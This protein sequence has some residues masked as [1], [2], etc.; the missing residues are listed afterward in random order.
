MRR[1]YACMY[2]NGSFGFTNG[3]VKMDGG[4]KTMITLSFHLNACSP[5][6]KK[7]SAQTK[8]VDRYEL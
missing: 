7:G 4:V 6:L 5:S 3:C 2:K 8:I 1:N